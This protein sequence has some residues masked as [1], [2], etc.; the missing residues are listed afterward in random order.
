MAFQHYLWCFWMFYWDGS[1]NS[2][3]LFD[4]MSLFFFA[5][6]IVYRVDFFLSLMNYQFILIKLH[7]T[8]IDH[9]IVYLIHFSSNFSIIFYSLYVWFAV[10]LVPA[11]EGNDSFRII[12]SL[13]FWFVHWWIQIFL[14][15][16]LHIFG[17]LC[18]HFNF[19]RETLSIFL[20]VLLFIWKN[21]YSVSMYFII[22]MCPPESFTDA[23][24]FSSLPQCIFSCFCYSFCFHKH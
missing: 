3:S 16:A 8:F 17:M 18:F 7:N 4:T 5:S 20:Y 12:G 13:L 9:L 14:V 23:H 15:V 10:V 22:A 2:F 6:F 24:I 11:F 21:W 1:N 19:F